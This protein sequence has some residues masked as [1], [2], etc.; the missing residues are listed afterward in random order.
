KNPRNFK[1]MGECTCSMD[2]HNPLCGD[3][4]TVFIKMDGDTLKDLSFIGTGCAISTASA[5]MLTETLKGKT[6]TDALKTFEDFHRMVTGEDETPASTLGKL[7]IFAGVKEF[8]M[9]VKCASLAW[10]TLKAALENK[11]E[12]VSTE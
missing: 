3:K 8:P 2:G 7:E 10:H 12:P 1:T 5:S 9:R 6:K 4:L 11:H